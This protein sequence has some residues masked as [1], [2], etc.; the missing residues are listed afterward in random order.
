MPCCMLCNLDPVIVSQCAPLVTT[1]NT[2]QTFFLNIFLLPCTFLLHIFWLQKND[3]FRTVSEPMIYA[4]DNYYIILNITI[5]F[6]IQINFYADN[7]SLEFL[8]LPNLFGEQSNDL[9]D[10]C[11]RLMGKGWDEGK[12]GQVK[13]NWVWTGQWA[14]PILPSACILNESLFVFWFVGT[15]GIWPAV[16]VIMSQ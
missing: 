10:W 14:A 9:T 2:Q 1:P 3:F 6:W 15:I 4:L 12:G 16:D 11:C 7:T 8:C 13:R 5:L